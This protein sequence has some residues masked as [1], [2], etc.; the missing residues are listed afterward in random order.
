MEIEGILDGVYL[1]EDDISKPARVRIDGDYYSTFEK[2]ILKE[3]QEGD[4]VK[5]KFH[6]VKGKFRTIDSIIR[7]EFLDDETK[8]QVLLV[9][10]A[11]EQI[12]KEIDKIM[13]KLEEKLYGA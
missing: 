13:D 12:H 5:I 6:M 10:K 3:F 8:S 11:K 1:Y 9:S 7:T 4:K 2:D